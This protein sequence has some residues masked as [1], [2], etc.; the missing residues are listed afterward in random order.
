MTS[1][2]LEEQAGIKEKDMI[3]CPYV[4]ENGTCDEC[5]IN[6]T[7]EE[8]EEAQEEYLIGLA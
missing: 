1:K 7:P 3:E 8:C 5:K 6:R 2:E 4:D